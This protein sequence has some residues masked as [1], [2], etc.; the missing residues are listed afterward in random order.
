MLIKSISSLSIKQK[1]IAATF[2]AV[3]IASSVV[4]VISYS[5]AQQMMLNRMEKAELPNLI[6]RIRNSIDGEISSMM[7]LTKSIATNPYL[8]NWLENNQNQSTENSELIQYLQN[9]KTENGLSGASFADRETARYWNNEGFLRVLKNDKYDGWF[10]GF[11][12]SGNA[13]SASTYTEVDGNTQIFV[14]YQ[15]LN[16]RGLGGTSKSFNEMVDYL[17]SFKIEESGFVYLVDEKGLVKVHKDKQKANK[18]SL[19]Q[20]YPDMN[21][22]S[23]LNG[24]NFSF[25]NND[26]LV[27]ASSYIPS[28]G[29]Y[30]IA[31]VPADEIY[32]D[33]EESRNYI[34]IS[35]LLI[36]LIFTFISFT[37]A[38][39][40]VKPINRIANLFVEL[41]QGEG[42]LK[43]RIRVDN[44][45][46]V[47]QLS[48]GFN[49]FISKIND[50]IKEVAVTSNQV[51]NTAEQV[52]DSAM[53]TKENSLAQKDKTIQV[54]TAINEMGETIT[55]I[56]KNA[57]V[58]AEATNETND[59]SLQAQDVVG[60]SSNSIQAMADN[61][62]SASGT[63]NI[64]ADK[65]S[66]ISAVLD[67]IRGISEQTN[68]L[69]LNAAIEAARAGENGR[70]F[71]VVADEVRGLAHR[72]SESTDEI[73]TMIKELQEQAKLAVDSVK[74][75]RTLAEQGNESATQ[76][77]QS[78]KDIVE[79]VTDIADLNIQ[80]ATA[81]EEQTA[82]VK[83][84]N[85]L[86][87]QIN[88][89]TESSAQTASELLSKKIISLNSRKCIEKR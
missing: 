27:L 3:T 75:S 23:L 41:G 18:I 28:L 50:V 88:E 20:L 6:Q 81:T 82:V 2:L 83:E 38:Q 14:N 77:N 65:T 24:N 44:E 10:F 55:D 54:V 73:A 61:M 87:N 58:A 34:A 39:V 63:I 17:N 5:K 9:I 56:A 45:D 79:K 67:V 69:A 89:T 7:A 37:L 74:Q 12:L 86:T 78:L 68:L 33:L 29:W 31:E 46:E 84:I 57:N 16:G 80:V 22:R 85:L 71:A 49:N 70:G 72:T 53:L 8:I 52:N 40:I 4:G 15:M 30:I 60:K 48:H 35:S 62:E 11:K 76:A 36:I 21:V 19:S 66:S 51:K 26:E 25:L 59:Y 64:L 42:D 43:Y 1:I 13:E 32:S 47:G